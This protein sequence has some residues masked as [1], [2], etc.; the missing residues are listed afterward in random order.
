MKTC[1]IIL[2]SVFLAIA[3]HAQTV[4]ATGDAS[5][6]TFLDTSARNQTTL[7]DNSRQILMK[8]GDIE[9]AL[10]QDSAA[11]A[12]PAAPAP[13]AA[14]SAPP[15]AG[16]EAVALQKNIN[17]V[18][19]LITAVLVFF[20]QA[21]FCML[22]VGFTRSKN[23]INVCMKNFL[24]F[25]VGALCFLFVG[26][27]LMFGASSMGW[28]GLGPFWIASH[29]GDD[30]FWA[31]WI[32]QTMFAATA[33]TIVSGAMAER[34]KFVGYLVFTVIMTAL[35]YPV[36]GHW[37]WGS[38]GGAFGYGGDAG[39]LEKLGYVDFAGSSIV[40][41]IGGSAALAGI[42][43]LGPRL[44][45]FRADGTPNLLS[46]HNLPL[47]ALGTFILW[48]G[49][50]GFN[51]GSTL[52][53]DFS[54]ARIAVNTTLAPA[55]GSLAA[56][57]AVWITQ[58]RPDLGA[59]LNG[60]LGGLVGI[61]ASCHTVSPASAVIIGLVAGVVA[62]LASQ[63]LDRAR[64]DDAVGAVPVHLACGWWGI[65]AVALFNEKGFSPSSLG[66]QALGVASITFFAFTL[67]FISFKLINATMGLRA[68][69]DEQDLGLDFSE[70]S[71]SAYADFL[72]GD[73]TPMESK[74]TNLR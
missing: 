23:A 25:S 64:I 50:Y 7:L 30:A 27:A 10:K 63:L 11:P 12:I 68:T 4:P 71:A 5:L 42:I 67:S 40:H 19:I 35:I 62:T 13:A 3:S 61:T 17:V 49:W 41:C 9:S 29:P 60:A 74:T 46:G 70:H 56:M 45:R 48:F 28:I 59:T 69:D 36:A 15:A 33:A 21:G 34:T 32:F 14:P 65:L 37:A 2:L 24:D 57:V 16:A 55:A 66:V 47:A 20:M 43:V 39:W 58:G 22:E 54:I 51:A 8:L 72:T 53:G 52:V 18:W 73:Q 44:G 31:F 1:A 26:F 6:D 38:L